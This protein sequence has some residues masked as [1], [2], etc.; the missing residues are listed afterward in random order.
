MC[1]LTVF[2]Y[3][4]CYLDIGVNSCHSSMCSQS[5]INVKGGFQFTC[6]SGYNLSS[7]NR[8]C[9]ANGKFSVFLL[10]YVLTNTFTNF[11]RT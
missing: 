4:F 1:L 8:I 9:A 2:A 3:C 7:D 6:K 11:N 5:C 10:H